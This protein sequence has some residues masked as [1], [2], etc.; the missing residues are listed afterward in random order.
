M[1]ITAHFECL[2]PQGLVN[3]S[4][5]PTGRRNEQRR[6]KL[7]KASTFLRLSLEILQMYHFAS[8]TQMLRAPSGFARGVHSVDRVH[9]H[10]G[11]ANDSPNL[12]SPER[13]IGFPGVLLSKYLLFLM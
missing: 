7:E 4:Q 9:P 3:P 13:T 11:L 2:N 5:H 10:H 6:K 12:C 8:K 1:E